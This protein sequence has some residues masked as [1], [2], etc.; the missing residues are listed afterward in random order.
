[1]FSSHCGFQ[2]SQSDI[3]GKCRYSLIHLASPVVFHS[4]SFPLHLVYIYIM[5]SSILPIFCYQSSGARE[6]FSKL[7]VAGLGCEWAL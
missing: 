3:P 2:R 1:M 7:Q 5:L 4:L 6:E